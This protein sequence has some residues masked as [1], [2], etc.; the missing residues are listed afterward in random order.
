MYAPS[1]NSNSSDETIDQQEVEEEEQ[2]EIALGAALFDLYSILL[3]RWSYWYCMYWK[4]DL[5]D[6]HVGL[7]KSSILAKMMLVCFGRIPKF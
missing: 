4:K 3:G 7:A 2:G 6:R 5:V 1:V